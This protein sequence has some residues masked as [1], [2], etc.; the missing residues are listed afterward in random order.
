MN[1]ET[2]INAAKLYRSYG[3]RE[4]KISGGDPIFWPHLCDYV[5]ALKHDMEYEHVELITRSVR[6]S[7]I[8]NQL[9]DNNLDMLNFSLDSICTGTGY[10]R[11][12][13]KPGQGGKRQENPPFRRETRHFQPGQARERGPFC[14]IT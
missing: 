12:R 9:A 10:L 11:K 14:Q 4:I 1:Y 7:E 8:I 2:A 13:D 6:V 3:G 5:H